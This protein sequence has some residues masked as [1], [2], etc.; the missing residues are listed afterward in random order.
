MKKI[1]VLKAYT[2]LSICHKYQNTQTKFGF[3]CK[4]NYDIIKSKLKPIE[5]EIEDKRNELAS[6]DDT[7]AKNLILDADKNYTYSKENDK[8][9]INYI[10]KKHE[11]E[12]EV[13]FYVCKDH[14]A[15][16]DNFALQL[17]LAETILPITVE[18]LYGEVPEEEK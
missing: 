2:L 4:R 5:V 1:T 11:S 14:S 13:E 9:I 8:L 3:A 6:T 15:V 18:E 7:P 12:I 17:E 10:R 16:K